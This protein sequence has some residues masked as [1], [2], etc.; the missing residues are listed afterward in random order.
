MSV[1][2][3]QSLAQS[4]FFWG[5]ERFDKE[6][7]QMFPQYMKAQVFLFVIQQAGQTEQMHLI[8]KVL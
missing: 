3:R 1:N 7:N 5:L 2:T 4:E 6:K 8:C